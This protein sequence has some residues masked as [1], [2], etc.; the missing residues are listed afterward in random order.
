MRSFFT[1]SNSGGVPPTGGALT[2]PMSPAPKAAQSAFDFG[3]PQPLTPQRGRSSPVKRPR[4]RLDNAFKDELKKSVHQI[5]VQKQKKKSTFNFFNRFKQRSSSNVVSETSSSKSPRR[6]LTSKPSPDSSNQA[7]NSRPTTAPNRSQG[8]MRNRPT[9]RKDVADELKMSFTKRNAKTEKASQGKSRPNQKRGPLI[10][11]L[12]EDESESDSN[13][14]FESESASDSSFADDSRQATS[15]KQA[16]SRNL[17]PDKPTSREKRSPP[18]PSRPRLGLRKDVADELRQSV[19]NRQ[20]KKA[21]KRTQLEQGE[22]ERRPKMDDRDPYHA[23]DTYKKPLNDNREPDRNRDSRDTKT[24]RRRIDPKL[25]NELRESVHSRNDKKAK[26]RREIA[27]RIMKRRESERMLRDAKGSTKGG[28]SHHSVSFDLS[29]HTGGSSKSFEDDSEN[30]DDRYGKKGASPH[31]SKR[32]VRK[33]AFPTA[34]IR[35]LL[36]RPSIH[37]RE[38]GWEFNSTQPLPA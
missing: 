10:N 12:E 8:M 21:Q 16:Q 29:N 22:R 38:S 2:P 5:V 33:R 9:L 32:T 31:R 1:R 20:A 24:N 23:G 30:V 27:A 15:S 36:C 37:Q 6:K 4:P 25:Q 14:S 18:A 3:R 17:Q 26:R 28:S 11:V 35:E 13:G 7:N 19:H 34:N